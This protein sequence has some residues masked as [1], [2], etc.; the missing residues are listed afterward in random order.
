MLIGAPAAPSVGATAGPG[1]AYIVFGRASFTSVL[2]LDTMTPNDGIKLFAATNGDR[3]GHSVSAAGDLNGDGFDDVIVGAPRNDLD[4][5]NLDVGQ[6]YI[7]FGRDFDDDIPLANEGTA[8]DDTLTGTAGADI[9]I[10]GQ[11]DDVLDG[12]AGV[13]S[14][15]GGAGDDILVF[16]ATDRRADGASGVDTLR[17][18]GGGLVLNLTTV[19]NNKFFGFERIDLTGNG[20]NSL[21]LN[22]QDVLDMTGTRIPGLSGGLSTSTNV[23]IVTGDAG[24]SVARGAGW[25]NSGAIT[26]GSVTY[27]HYVSGIAHLLVHQDVTQTV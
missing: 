12:G 18:D 13:D 14:L 16:G 9:L 2:N 23:L 22:I 4:L 19:P 8:G 11:G 26:E 1:E 17:F 25:T 24:D 10:G 27:D 3:T 5:V 21:T 6:S 7:V 15:N 20:N